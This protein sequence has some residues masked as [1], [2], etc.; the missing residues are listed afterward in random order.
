MDSSASILY[1]LIQGITEFLPVSSS[2]HLA[3]LPRFLTIKD[4]GVLF[5]LAMHVGTAFS[6]IIYFHKEVNSIFRSLFGIIKE[7]ASYKTQG[8]WVSN[9]IVAT[10]V[11]FGFVLLLKPFAE[12]YARN[13]L[14]I[15]VNLT[16]F[17]LLMLVADLKGPKQAQPVMKEL[18]L[19]KAALIGFGQALAI[20]PGVSRS[21]ATLT[22][23]RFLN[24]SRDEATRF[25]FLLSLPIIL[26]GFFYKLPTLL[27]E[28]SQFDWSACF[29]GM[30]VS[31]VVGLVTIHFFL[32]VIK[33]LGLWL[34]SLYRLV[35]S[36]IIL[37]Y[38]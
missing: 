16:A 8:A 17:G 21:G 4:P 31:F 9:M 22:V 36:F 7:P 25:S 30:I 6:I 28:G 5:D 32:K 1:G 35:L 12:Q 20:F 37:F 38:L 3:L 26:A 33:R 13:P 11:T 18:R 15:I 27:E 23:A 19:A 10:G 29:I 34:F 24:L 14:W 2:G